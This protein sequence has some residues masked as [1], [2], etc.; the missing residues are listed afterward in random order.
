MNSKERLLMLSRRFLS[1][2]IDMVIVPSFAFIIMWVTGVLEHAEDFAGYRPVITALLLG[3]VSYLILNG[4]LLWQRGQTIGKALMGISIVLAVDSGNVPIW[5]LICI[6][7]L[8]FPLLYLA[9]IPWFVLIPILDHVL[10][11]G[12]NQRCLHDYISGTKVS[13]RNKNNLGS[14]T[15]ESL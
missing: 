14:R 4:W 10:I 12:K 1:T 6:R 8:F 15:H 11:L 2:L 9:V 13:Y 7:A 5:R 3:V